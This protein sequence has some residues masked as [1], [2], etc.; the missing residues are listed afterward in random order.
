MNNSLIK[1]ICKYSII[2]LVIMVFVTILFMIY[3]KSFIWINVSFD[4]LDQHFVNLRLLRNFL[5]GD[6]HTF[7]WNIG[8]GMD[9]FANFTYYI[10]GD[11]PSFI[12]VFFPVDKLDIAYMLIIFLRVYLVGLSFILYTNDKDYSDNN[13]IIGSILYTFSTFTLFAM[14]RHPYFLNAMIIFPI[15]LLSVEKLVLEDK[16]IFFTDKLFCELL[17]F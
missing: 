17:A 10:F 2:Y 11:F 16:K 15:L 13:I 5:L 9:L 1:K 3:N 14:A 7:F 6:T 8:Y 4:G 12:S